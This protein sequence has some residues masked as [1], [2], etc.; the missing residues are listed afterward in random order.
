M[1]SLG[2]LKRPGNQIS[3]SYRMYVVINVSSWGGCLIGI[4]SRLEATCNKDNPCCQ[5]VISIQKINLLDV[6]L[7]NNK[8]ELLSPALLPAGRLIWL[9]NLGALFTGLFIYWWLGRSD[10]DCPI[11]GLV[12]LLECTILTYFNFGLKDC[13]TTKIQHHIE[14]IL[15]ENDNSVK[16]Y[17]VKLL[18]LK[19]QHQQSRHQTKHKQIESAN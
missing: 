12:L 7:L 18:I 4:Q 19:Y 16:H 10:D 1:H 9:W 14:I 11:F 2:N 15:I 17:I 13:N 8:D 5:S 6:P 3:C